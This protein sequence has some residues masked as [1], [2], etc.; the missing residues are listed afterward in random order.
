MHPHNNFQ[1]QNGVLSGTDKLNQ[2]LPFT[3]DG[4]SLW[5]HSYDV[6]VQVWSGILNNKA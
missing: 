1:Y 2:Y 5:R 4:K 6:N 3:I